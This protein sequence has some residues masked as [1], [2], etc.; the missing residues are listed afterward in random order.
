M[1]NPVTKNFRHGRIKIKSGDTTPLEK[2]AD[3]SEGDFTFGEQFPV[4][5]VR[6]R[7]KLREVTRGDEEPVTWSFSAKFRDKTLLR[8][9][10][11]KVWDAQAVTK[12]GLTGGAVNTIT[13]DYPFEQGSVEVTD[14]GTWTKLAVDATPSS[15]RDYA[16]VAGEEDIEGVVRAT[17]FKVK[18]PAA[19]VDLGYLIDAVGQG[20]LGGAT[21]QCQG[22]VKAFDLVLE[23]FDPCDPPDPDDEDAGTI[24]ERYTLSDAFLT[25]DNFNEAA[26]ADMVAFSGEALISKVVITTVA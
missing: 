6:S 24:V 7:G 5:K 9:L 2:V 3:F 16:E 21:D 10:R 23:I 1:A 17:S 11:D 25:G 14:T 12:T 26:E 8:T 15:D 13:P 19:D 22:G 20:T 4:N 18:M